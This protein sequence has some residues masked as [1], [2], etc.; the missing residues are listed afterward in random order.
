VS[1]SKRIWY[2]PIL[3]LPVSQ[4]DLF[5]ICTCHDA[6]HHVMQTRVPYQSWADVGTMLLNLQNHE[7]SKPF[8]GTLPRLRYSVIAMENRLNTM[9]GNAFVR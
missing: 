2:C 7:L 6:I 1:Y 3:W 4:W 9:W 5:L 8:F